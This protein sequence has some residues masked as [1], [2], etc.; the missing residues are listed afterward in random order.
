MN[1]FCGNCGAEIPNGTLTGSGAFVGY[2][3]ENDEHI[4]VATEYTFVKTG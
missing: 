3:Y 1:R 4:D 2:I